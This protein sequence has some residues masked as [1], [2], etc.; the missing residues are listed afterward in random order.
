MSKALVDF[1]KICLLDG[2]I[3][4]KER[5][6]IFNKAKELGISKEE[7]E[8]TIDS[9]TKQFRSEQT[10]KMSP[11]AESRTFK[12]KKANLAKSQLEK[13]KKFQKKKLIKNNFQR[14]NLQIQ[15][16]KMGKFLQAQMQKLLS[17]KKKQNHYLKSNQ[18]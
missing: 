12:K 4:E 8:I 1:I 11:S 3:S 10:E 2:E 13:N 15:L 18:L 17:K 9:L 5:N 14:V 6:G 16:K 7:C